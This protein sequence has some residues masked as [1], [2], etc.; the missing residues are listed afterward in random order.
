M[1]ARLN[2]S[3]IVIHSNI[4]SLGYATGG[5]QGDTTPY[6]GLGVDDVIAYDIVLYDG[7]N[8][9]ASQTEHPNLY[10]YLRGKS[11]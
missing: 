2:N 10:W 11:Q 7:R 8:I 1:S 9:T 6:V 5:G 4:Y 3:G